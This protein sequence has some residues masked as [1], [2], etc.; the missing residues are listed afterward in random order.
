VKLFAYPLNRPNFTESGALFLNFIFYGNDI[1][2]REKKS[3]RGVSQLKAGFD[4]AEKNVIFAESK[5]Y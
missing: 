5:Q 3:P 1:R 4:H 2:E